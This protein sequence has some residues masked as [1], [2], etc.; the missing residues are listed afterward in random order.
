[1]GSLGAARDRTRAVCVCLCARSACCLFRASPFSAQPPAFC[2]V[3]EVF[4]LGGLSCSLSS[5]WASGLLSKWHDEAGDRAARDLSSGMW[6]GFCLKMT[7][8]T[9]ERGGVR[10]AR[11]SSDRWE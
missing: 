8:R 9:H 11:V 6:G 7:G 10:R 1:M 2:C 5:G 3:C 4:E